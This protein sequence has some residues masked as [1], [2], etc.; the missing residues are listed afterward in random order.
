[1]RPAGAA[2]ALLSGGAWGVAFWSW[3]LPLPVPWR[4]ASTV[5]L[6][7][8]LAAS[9]RAGLVAA[10]AFAFGMGAGSSLVLAG[11]GILFAD[12][13]WLVPAAALVTGLALASVALAR[14]T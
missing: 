14:D 10:A 9:S 13:W 8:A 11:N 3:G 7:L 1:V 4:V 2:L 5:L 12:W 6:V